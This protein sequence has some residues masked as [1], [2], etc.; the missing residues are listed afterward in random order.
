MKITQALRD[1]LKSLAGSGITDASTDDQCKSAVGAAIANGTL[2]PVKLSELTADKAG[3]GEDR[4]KSIV[5]A[6]FAGLKDSITDGIKAAFAGLTLKAPEAPAV[7]PPAAQTP[8]ATQTQGKF[9]T[10]DEIKAIAEG[11]VKAYGAGNNRP[12]P[13]DLLTRGASTEGGAEKHH[14]RVKSAIE[15]YDGTKSTLTYSMKHPDESMRGM[16]IVV[17][18]RTL[19]RPSQQ[20]KAVIGV[21]TKW[22]TG[23]SMGQPGFK[24]TEHDNNILEYAIKELPW[25]GFVGGDGE[26]GHGTYID[27]R[28]L[29]E[30][31]QKA[32]LNDTISG[33]TY[34]VPTIYDDTPILSPILTGE[35]FPY[36]NVIP[37]ARG[38]TVRAFSV[39]S[40]TITSGIPEGTSIPLFDTTGFIAALDTTIYPAVGAIEIGLDFE[41]DSPANFGAIVIERYGQKMLEWLDEQIANGDGTT[42]N[43]A[44]G[45]LTISDLESL[46]FGVNIA[47]RR[48]GGRMAF[49]MNDVSYRRFRAI[50]SATGWNTRLF[51]TNYEDYTLLG[52]PVR[53]VPTV[54]NNRIAFVNLAMYR[55]YRRQGM[56]VRVITDGKDLALTNQKL[57]VTR[58]L[59]G[60]R[61]EQGGAGTLMLDAQS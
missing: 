56:Q 26:N 39:G 22:M 32:L 11:V 25:V 43:G 24:M 7:P 27:N 9:Y 61:L 1:F 48:R 18:E 2:S 13:H 35:L 53:I 17:G 14:I 30:V 50:A 34:A 28:K 12:S 38:K 57:I 36:V 8:P 60:G 46:I 41:E 21:F 37:L 49:I 6:E 15:R 10:D 23:V 16:P 47:Y 3:S 40:P 59:W 31:E 5:Q 52:Y 19:N 45:P 42:V 29:T 54:P 51:G 44:G 58:S 20:D 33:G 4:V 55:L